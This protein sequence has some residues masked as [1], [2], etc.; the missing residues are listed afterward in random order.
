MRLSSRAW[1]FVAVL[2]MDM[3]RMDVFLK[4]SF[5]IIIDKG[6]HSHAHPPN[7]MTKGTLGM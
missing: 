4:G 3:R 2:V 7:D 6:T 1:I 5:D